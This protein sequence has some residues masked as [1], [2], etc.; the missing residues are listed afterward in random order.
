MT[1]G[2]HAASLIEEFHLSFLH[3]FTTALKPNL[4]VLKGGANLRYFFGSLR[5]SQDI[6]LDYL[7]NQLWRL[8][9]VVGEVLTGA[10]LRLSLRTSGIALVDLTKSKQTET[11]GCWKMGLVSSCAPEN[12]PARTKIEFS[13]RGGDSKYD[14][15]AVPDSVIGRYGMRSFS[16]Q[17]YRLSAMIEQKVAALANRSETKARDVFD[18]DLLFRLRLKSGNEEPIESVYA[19]Q[20]SLRSLSLSDESFD[21]E[22]VPFLEPEIAKLYEARDTWETMRVFVCESLGALAPVSDDVTPSDLD[23]NRPGPPRGRERRVRR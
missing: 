19:E 21:N 8:E 7:G 22:V 12:A 16:V 18:L 14:F 20:A 13:A 2:N 5:Y 4:Y 6:D 3:V 1:R 10:A 17:R 15:L 23:F 9:E 11:T